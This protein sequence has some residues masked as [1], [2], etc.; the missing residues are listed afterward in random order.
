ML[1][2][3][4]FSDKYG[5]YFCTHPTAY[6]VVESYAR[7][8]FPHYIKKGREDIK[9]IVIVGGYIGSEVQQYLNLYPNSQIFV[10]EPHPRHY[11]ILERTY[12]NFSNVFTYK[13]AVSNKTGVQTFYDVSG[14]GQS[15]LKKYQGDICGSSTKLVGDFQVETIRLDDVEE[16]KGKN[17]DYLQVDVQGGELLVLQGAGECL[18]NVRSMMLECHTEDYIKL[19]DKEPYKDQCYL[20]DLIKHFQETGTNI[21]CLYVGLDNHN[22]NGQG[23]SF[24]LNSNLI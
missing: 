19:A 21:K 11:E 2:Q 1:K 24:W 7:V 23:N 22:G 14:E 10:F 5:T 12:R 20:Q 4:E 15:S 13:K 6:D 3:I 8:N 9:N 17:I 16:I 18:A